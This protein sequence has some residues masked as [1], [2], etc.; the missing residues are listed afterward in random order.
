M[1]ASA[2]DALVAASPQRAQGTH[3]TQ[4]LLVCADAGTGKTWSSVQLTEALARKCKLLANS[5]STPLVPAL[6]YVQRVSRMLKDCDEN[7][8]LDERVL[9]QY[10]TREFGKQP[11]RLSM[12]VMALEMRSLVVI[13]ECV[14]WS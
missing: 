4:P 10:F 2:R 6:V 5:H 8:P 14:S 7:M 13:L 12:L 1:G 9:L 11:E 3:L